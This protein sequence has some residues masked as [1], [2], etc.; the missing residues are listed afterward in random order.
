M[1]MAKPMEFTMVS[2]VPRDSPSALF[3]TMVEKSGESATT[4][5]PQNR[6]KIISK[7]A[8]SLKKMKGEIKQQIPE[9]LRAAAAVFFVPL[10]IEI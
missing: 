1:V 7:I 10:P 9:R 5:A 3:A 6:R 8:E 4:T 2:A